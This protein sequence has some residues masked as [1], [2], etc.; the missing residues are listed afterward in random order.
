MKTIEFE[1]LYDAE[2]HHFPTDNKA[3]QKQIKQLEKSLPASQPK[4]KVSSSNG[5]K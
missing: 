1:M 5:N 2:G 4:P 3:A